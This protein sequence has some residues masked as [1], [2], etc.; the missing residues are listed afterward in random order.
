M[1]LFTT[2][3]GKVYTYI[4]KESSSRYDKVILYQYS[5][6]PQFSFPPVFFK[7]NH[8]ALG[9]GSGMMT[10]SYFSSAYIYFWGFPLI[11]VKCNLAPLAESIT[12]VMASK[13]G[14]NQTLF[15]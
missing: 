7:P 9:K 6:F 11:N 14:G 8:Y 2:L 13:L 12:N 4:W 15:L 10:S 1:L 3:C 5:N